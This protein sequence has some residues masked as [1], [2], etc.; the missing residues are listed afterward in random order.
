M[1]LSKNQLMFFYW[2]EKYKEVDYILKKK[3]R[4][5]TIEVKSNS[6]TYNAGLEEIRKKYHPYATMVVGEGGMKVEDFLSIN[7]VK[8]FK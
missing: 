6:E 7:P 4:I 3:S 8:L 1:P 5:V 2:R